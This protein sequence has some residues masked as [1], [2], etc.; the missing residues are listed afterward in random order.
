MMASLFGKNKRM[1]AGPVTLECTGE[2]WS[3]D[4]VTLH[5]R[6]VEI[7]LT[8]RLR[9]VEIRLTMREYEA[10]DADAQERY[11][12]IVRFVDKSDVP[13]VIELSE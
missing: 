8:M 11:R 6:I 7:R 12:G 3:K 13:Y 10:M 2:T 1:E 5:L 4:A 9:I